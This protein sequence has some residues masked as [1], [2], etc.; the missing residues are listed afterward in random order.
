VTAT[1]DALL[2][3]LAR[4]LIGPQDGPTEHL[5]R[6]WPSDQYIAGILYP[7]QGAGGDDEAVQR[8]LEDDD[9]REGVDDDEG[10]PGAAVPTSMTRRPSVMGV[11]F[12][13][14]GAP[15]VLKLTAR[16]AR[17]APRFG[18]DEHVPESWLRNET[19]LSPPTP[20]A[21]SRGL[22]SIEV[23]GIGRWWVRGLA[24]GDR[25][26][27]TV[28]FEN[29]TRAPPGRANHEAAH[30]FQTWFAVEGGT[31]TRIVPRR[32]Q[33]PGGH[34]ALDEDARIH[35]L[36]YRDVKEYAVGHTCGAT[37]HTHEGRTIVET[38][39]IPQHRVTSMSANGHVIFAEESAAR[40]WNGR[41]P[42][43]ASALADAPDAPTLRRLLET[44][45]VAY[46]RWQREVSARIDCEAADGTL[47]APRAQQ[48][49][50]NL[51]TAAKASARIRAGI[52]ALC[53][54]GAERVRRAFQ[55]AQRAMVRQRQ[56]AKDD[57]TLVWRPFQI[58]FQLLALQ[59][60]AHP[61]GADGAPNADRGVMDLLWFPTGGGK[62]E[63][64][65]GLTAFTLFWRR[66]RESDPDV[67]AGVSVLMRYTLRLLTVQQFERASRLI[68]ACEHLRRE[69]GGELGTVPFSIGLWVG[70][71]ATPATVDAARKDPQE[72]RRAQQLARCPACGKKTLKWDCDVKV[73]SPEFRVRCDSRACPT[74]GWT[75]PVWTIDEDVFR[76]RPGLVIGTLDKFAQIVRNPGSHALFDGAGGPPELIIQDE[77]HL[78][79]G[80]LGTV[81]GVYECAIDLLCRRNGVGPKILGSTATIRRAREQVQQLFDRDVMQ[82][83]P[84][85]LDASDS[86]FAV[87]D[88]TVPGRLYAGV[89]TAGRSPKF[90]LQATCASLLQGAAEDPVV[91]PAHRDAYWTLVAYFNSL[92]EL[93]GALVMMQDD[94][95]DSIKTFA[96]LH[97]ANA[98]H[99][100]V[101]MELTSRVPQEEI[102][103]RLTDLEK[104]YE[105]SMPLANQSQHCAIVLATNMISVGVDVSRL[106]L[107]VVHGQ[108]KTMAEYIQA[109]SRVGRE[110]T[111]GLVVT[112]YNAGR[113]RDRSHFEAFVSWHQT[114]Y[115]EVEAT[116]VTPFA[117]RA[118]DRAL[119]APLVALARH[120]VPGMLDDTEIR[121]DARAV[122]D[123]LIDDMV[124]RAE[125][126]DPMERDDVAS[127]LRTFVDMWEQRGAVKHYWNDH[128]ASESLLVS[129]EVVAE[130][131]AAQTRWSTSAR[132]T[133]NSMRDVEA[134]VQFR[135]ASV[136]KQDGG[137]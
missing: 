21:V 119:H 34:D 47:S 9:D 6:V 89:T 82:F 48:A 64:Y 73:P 43:D 40:T 80:P 127:E 7:P 95:R 88:M 79:S 83:P 32:A 71:N 126:L 10:G 27:V 28:A 63:A 8:A 49:R 69:L 2:A 128:K 125:R 45:P 30:L 72:K 131:R 101:P 85:V 66:L 121:P 3:Q 116:S 111:A 137:A 39:W 92:R 99:L 38:T 57:S 59:G 14:E 51:A 31:G 4:D 78:I 76:A 103:G 84:P 123:E 22:Q 70:N 16:A 17:Y 102:P 74:N 19:D 132:A 122:L 100:D 94:V 104:R 42:F 91:P 106:G 77:L 81:A 135:M 86:C 129:A 15:P 65:L 41:F 98:R 114:L 109:T 110:Q 33:R 118:R 115:R 113:P 20:V 44:V 120:L 97:R 35:D 12:A 50:E 112:L 107:M 53:D 46:E 67:G 87:V 117:P 23:P 124:A 55:L 52:D 90:V 75:L 11:S 37:W 5:V 68:V 136:L 25:W 58:A 133:P 29:T 56:W 13:V 130:W 26:Q 1:R 108:P 134:Q 93:G 54:A 105:P 18:E 61:R 96:A 62:T 36:I 24:Q 60:L